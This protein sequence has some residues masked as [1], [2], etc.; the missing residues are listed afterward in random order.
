MKVSFSAIWKYSFLIIFLTLVSLYSFELYGK[1]GEK[2]EG[3]SYNN[4]LY[5][6]IN[7]VKNNTGDKDVILTQWTNAPFIYGMA[8][9]NVIATTKVY[10]SEVSIVGERY[11]DLSRFYFATEEKKALEVARKYNA[12]YV[13]AQRNF[14]FQNCGYIRACDVLRNPG[15]VM[16]YRL[17][18]NSNLTNFEPVYGS[19][20]FKVYKV[21]PLEF[22]ESNSNQNILIKSF[23]KQKIRTKYENVVGAVMPHDITH[24]SSIIMENLGSMDKNYSRII[25]LGPDHTPVAGYPITTSDLK[26]PGFENSMEPDI[27]SIRKIGVPLDNGAHKFEWSISTLVPFIDYWQKNAYIVPVL[28][29]FDVPYDEAVSFGQKLSQIIDNDTLVVAS[30]DFSHIMPANSNINAAEDQRSLKALSGF[31]KDEIYHLTAEGKPAL[32]A[33]LT[34]MEG[35]HAL[36]VR[37]LNIS[38]NSYPKGSSNISVGYISLQY[39]K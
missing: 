27:N 39:S 14:D 25:V 5:D 36:K 29:R 38:S 37:L 4:E 2:K 13:I 34:A 7:W 12:T 3:H 6:L 32:V 10:P 20:S 33:F 1:M 26:W 21:L 8:D 24:S 18:N 16:I 15:N 31:E 11:S 9:R 17:L 30:I 35:Q 19:E 28:F 23:S 22:N